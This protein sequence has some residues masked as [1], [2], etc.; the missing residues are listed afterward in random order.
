M[1]VRRAPDGCWDGLP[2]VLVGLSGPPTGVGACSLDQGVIFNF[3]TLEFCVMAYTVEQ[4]EA[5]TAAIA[6]GSKWVK[7]GD[8]EVEYRCQGTMLA[9]KREMEIELG[10]IKQASR[11]RVGVYQKI[12]RY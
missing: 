2:D 5:L 11:R 10:L 7:Y 1:H 9:L 4:Y 12:G 6:T 8:K 3:L